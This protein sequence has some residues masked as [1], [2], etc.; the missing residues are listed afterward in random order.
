MGGTPSG[1]Q[2]AGYLARYF[3]DLGL[4]TTVIEDP[5]LPA[6]WAEEWR[7]EVA[8][9]GGALESA[10]PYAFSP[11]VES[12]E[13]PL[14]AVESLASATPD[15][16]WS[17]AVI[18]TP[19]RVDT[20]YN[21]FSRTGPRPLA[22]VT[23]S[24]HTPAKNLDW[25]RPG[26]LPDDASNPIAVFAVSYVD[27]RTLAAAAATKGRVRVSLASRSRQAPSKTVVAT[28]R[29]LSDAY[30]LVSAHGDSDS[31][32]PGA[33]DNASGVAT[34]MEIARILASQAARGAFK[35]R[36]SVRFVVWGA[37]YHSARAYIAREGA[38][39]ARCEGVINFDETGAGAE[40]EAI[41]IEGN[42]VPWNES[43]LRTLE[44]VGLDYLDRPGF[45]PEVTTNPTQGGTD[46]YA[47][48]PREYKGSGYTAEKIPATTI[49]TAAWD[50]TA[51][52]AQTPG[53]ESKGWRGGQELK[54]DYSLYYH[55][56]GDTPANTTDREPQN[57]V[58]AVKLAGIGL[59]R[60]LSTST[61]EAQ[62]N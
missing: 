59:L 61:T 13:A 24:P 44:R 6:Y 31:G 42:D 50:E 30:L 60:L 52:L 45:W 10:W 47:F 34:V 2:A 3:G 21:L 33:D 22:I 38:A 49:Y 11:A 37:E 58:R 19:G 32:G 55:S 4:E 26:A 8:P 57:M 53:W 25:S 27:G 54:I 23:S 51:T 9:S 14:L 12:S 46:S 1:D 41:Y 7:V 62:R 43:L 39:L 29:G 16:S 48:L 5:P 17:G 18:Y 40:R 15:D 20:A 56:S 28:L 36:L 35:P